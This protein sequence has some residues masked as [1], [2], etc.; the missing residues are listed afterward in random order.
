M[1]V[2]TRKIGEDIVIGKDRLV[3]VKV[4]N[5]QGSQVKL[6]IT[7]PKHIPVHRDEIFELIEAGENS[8]DDDFIEEIVIDD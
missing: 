4:I 6:G 5:I 1:L 3:T 7:A 2:L 8:S